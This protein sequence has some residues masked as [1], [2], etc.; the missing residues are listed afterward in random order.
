[1]TDEWKSEDAF[2]KFNS[3]ELVAGL[4]YGEARL[5]EDSILDDIKEYIAIGNVVE[6]RV[7]AG[8][9]PN[10]V[11]GVILQPKQ[12]SCFN[13]TDPNR[14][15]IYEFLSTKQPS[16]QYSRLMVFAYAT[17]WRLTVDFSNGATH[18][19]ARWFYETVKESHWCRMMIITACYGG[20]IFL[21]EK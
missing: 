15:L 20:H 18:Y 14:K 21:K 7:K 17:S 11:Y 19:V 5:V 13:I 2:K 10:D 16:N 1:M 4:C 6:N 8:R 3:T 9:F 12:F